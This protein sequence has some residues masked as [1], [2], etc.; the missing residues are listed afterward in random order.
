MELIP[1]NIRYIDGAYWLIKLRW[2]AISWVISAT[3]IIKKFYN[4]NI[5][6][7]PF[8][9]VCL[10]LILENIISLLLLKY[11]RQKKTE[12]IS[13]FITKIINFQILFDLLFLTILIHFS[14]GIENPIFLFFIFHMVISS[15][16]LSR[17][18]SYLQTTYALFLLWALAF[19]EYSGVINHYDL[20]MKRESGNKLFC[21]SFFLIETLTI[22][23]ITSYSLVYIC[24]YIM[25]LLRKQ[26][27][28][29][30]EA[31]TLL[32]HHNKIKD[33]YILRVTHNIKGHLAAIQTNLSIITDKILGT[34]E[35]K[36]AE[37]IDIAYFRIIKL[38]NFVN[39]LLKLT[40]MRLNDKPEIETFSLK[41]LLLNII[42]KLKSLSDAK[43]QIFKYSIDNTIDYITS[44]KV[45]IE[46]LISNLI[47]NAIKY[48]HEKGVIEL[49]VKDEKDNILIEVTDTGIGISEKDMPN[50]FNEFY[51]AN[52]A[53][54][55]AKDGTG[56][57]LAMSKYIVN[58][59]G[60]KIW[61]TS[62]EGNGS[63]FYVT[64][65]KNYTETKNKKK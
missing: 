58:R 46:E 41:E 63:I 18:N 21:D 34:I 27:K 17:L 26:E 30:H 43:S 53:K 32:Q 4:I 1:R 24:N 28:A 39:D 16:L 40:Q 3:L 60:G 42:T 61:A 56:L 54:D 38:S 29:Y 7:I 44:N 37:F 15:I 64:L 14:G 59:Y 8:Y 33:E 50:I 48:T 36:Q 13:A 52:N 10:A 47:E 11:S 35:E 49:C 12:D 20:W 22:F 57:G 5:H 31:N 19:L 2:F 51:R 62:N 55:I 6:D 9:I 23:T 65:P 45:S 25:T